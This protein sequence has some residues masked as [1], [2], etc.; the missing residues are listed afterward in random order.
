MNIFYYVTSHGYGHGVRTCTIADALPQDYNITFR[1]TLPEHFFREEVKRD[2]RYI[3]G[4]FDC[5]CLQSDGVTINVSA[6]LKHYEQ[7][8]LRNNNIIENEIA[9]C[10]EMKVDGIISDITPFA[11]EIAQRYSIPSVAVTNFSWYDV[12]NEYASEHP[13]YK[14]LIDNIRLQYEKADL[15]LALYP[16]LP[17]NYFRNRIDTG[18]VGRRG[19]N[20]HSDIISKYNLDPSKKTGLIYV[21]NFGM[22]TAHWERLEEFTDWQFIGVYP[23]HGNPS[24][25]RLV[26][27]D[28]FRYQDLISSCDAMISKLGYGSVSESMLNG[29]PIIYLP[30]TH[31]AEY[32]LLEKAVCDWG[33]GVKLETESFYELRWHEAL[34]KAAKMQ[35]EQVNSTGVK[36]AVESVRNFFGR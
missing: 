13:E 4:E 23:V 32:P 12:Y 27:K 9:L 26:S 8:A 28:N 7:I 20:L 15:L 21:G 24:N 35:L 25:Y 29:K 22:H 10:R 1:T 19:R 3:P 11:F 14:P 30:R 5:G 16:A 18:L 31:F 36:T 17:M 2:F 34:E 6:T 33:G